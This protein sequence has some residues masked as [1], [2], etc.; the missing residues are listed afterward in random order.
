VVTAKGA[1][2]AAVKAA[3]LEAVTVALDVPEYKVSVL[4][5]D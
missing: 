4:S 3:V 1:K 2:D 5:G